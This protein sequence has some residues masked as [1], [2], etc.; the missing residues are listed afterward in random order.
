MPKSKPRLTKSDWLDAA[1]Q[2][3]AESGTQ[4][5]A[6]EPLARRLNVTKGSF[7]WHFKNRLELLHGT[8][9]YWHEIEVQY[10]ES[11]QNEAQPPLK[12]LETV[13]T[14]LVTDDTNRRV[15]LAISNDQGD[16]V[17]QQSYLAAVQRR[18]ELFESTLNAIGFSSKERKWRATKLYLDYLG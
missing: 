8:L 16:Q 17:L 12:F 1:L 6:V 4:G 5:V 2:L 15:F 13:M 9:D 7:Y 10:Q 14:L 18:Y 11:L 3:L